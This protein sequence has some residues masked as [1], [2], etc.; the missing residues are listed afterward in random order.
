[1]IDLPF[2]PILAWFIL[3]I[4]FYLLELALPAFVV[5]FFGIGAWCTALAL[6][7]F[8]LSL[9]A[10]LSCFLLASLV[11]LFS[12]RSSLRTVF[13]GRSKEESDSVTLD[14]APA[15]GTVTEA[16]RPPAEG[17]IK[18]AGSFWRAAADEEISPGTTVEIVDQ[19]DLLVR[20]RPLK[21]QGEQ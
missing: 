8:E 20:V 18:Y 13:M 16:I 3:G 9:S 11:A 12:L 15:T 17:K 19:Q 2:S 4:L 21:T 7:L 6:A 14:P 1:M 5:F 10:Q